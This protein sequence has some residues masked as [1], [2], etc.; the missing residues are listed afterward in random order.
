MGSKRYKLQ[1]LEEFVRER[2]PELLKL[3]LPEGRS[4]TFP[5]DLSGARGVVSE[6]RRS[7]FW[8]NPFRGDS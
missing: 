6:P 3:P 8:R 2:H 1:T 7:P 4:L 5:V